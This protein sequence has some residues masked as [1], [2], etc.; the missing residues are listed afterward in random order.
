MHSIINSGRFYFWPI[1]IANTAA[2]AKSANGDVLVAATLG[3]SIAC[4][5]SYGFLLN[6]LWDQDIDRINV[7]HHFEDET[8]IVKRV[9]GVSA[10]L[11]LILGLTT[12]FPLGR[13]P[14]AIAC[15]IAV[16]LTAYTCV[17]RPLL[18]APTLLSALLAGSPLIS[19]LLLPGTGATWIHWTFAFSFML[20]ITAREILMDVRDRVGD[21][22][23]N[24]RTMPTVYGPA[25]AKRVALSLIVV[26]LGILLSTLVIR[27]PQL[28]L[29]QAAV[30]VSLGTAIVLAV[31]IPGWRTISDSVDE[32][33][34]IQRF[35]LASRA[36]MCLVPIVVLALW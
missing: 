10:V 18:I 22:K 33:A 24:R 35:V 4:L 16:G 31:W 27:V 5:A 1:I 21:S 25:R 17:L 2:M 34:R 15:L 7:A 13:L 9:G 26:G 32:S 3:L 36:A 11:F 28:S 23:G 19:P 20:I 8:T 29:G 6:D 14:F 30:S 12:A